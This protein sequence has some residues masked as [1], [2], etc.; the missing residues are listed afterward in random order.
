MEMLQKFEE[1][2]ENAEGHI[3]EATEIQRKTMATPGEQHWES[4]SS[5]GPSD[6]NALLVGRHRLGF[7]NTQHCNR[8]K[9]NHKQLSVELEKEKQPLSIQ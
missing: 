8:K 3:K 6:D 4:S 7:G 1:A 2:Q 5:T 9:A